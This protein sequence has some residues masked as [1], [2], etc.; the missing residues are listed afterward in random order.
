MSCTKVLK[1]STLA[2]EDMFFISFT[3][4]LFHSSDE[5]NNIQYK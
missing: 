5:E 4:I 2:F 3:K 1:N